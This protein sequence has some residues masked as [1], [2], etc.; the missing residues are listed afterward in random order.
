M[1]TKTV[2]DRVMVMVKQGPFQEQLFD[3]SIYKKRLEEFRKNNNKDAPQTQQ[4]TEM[5]TRKKDLSELMTNQLSVL[6][7]IQYLLSEMEKKTKKKRR[8]FFSKKEE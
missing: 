2:A 3:F 4:A 7:D 5:A 8:W 6:Q 1:S